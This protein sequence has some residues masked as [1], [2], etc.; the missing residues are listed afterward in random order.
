MSEH[1]GQNRG[2]MRQRFDAETK[3]RRRE[4]ATLLIKN[5]I[6]IAIESEKHLLA[7]S[8]SHDSHHLETAQAFQHE[9]S[10]PSI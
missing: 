5:D 7:N 2:L 6:K 4:S 3:I 9:Q 8:E 1:C 10:L